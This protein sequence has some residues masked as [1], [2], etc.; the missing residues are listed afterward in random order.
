MARASRIVTL[1][2]TTDIHIHHTIICTVPGTWYVVMVIGVNL[3][4]QVAA[5][6]RQYNLLLLSSRTLVN[7]YKFLMAY[8]EEKAW[9]FLVLLA[10]RV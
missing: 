7:L 9:Y 6:Q 4:K 5:Q 8:A 2:L 3:V 10:S 1:P